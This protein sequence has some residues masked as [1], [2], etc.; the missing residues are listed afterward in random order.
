MSQDTQDL[1]N[2][3]YQNTEDAKQWRLDHE[4]L[5]NKRFLWTLVA[6]LVMASATGVLPQLLN[7][8][9]IGG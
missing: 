9:K 6:I 4:K 1:L 7:H 8:I 3:I 2:K 5:D